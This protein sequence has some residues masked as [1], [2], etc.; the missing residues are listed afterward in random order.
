MI[1]FDRFLCCIS[2]KTFGKFIGWIGTMASFMMIY[3]L[4]LVL[5]AK[6]V[7][8]LSLNE[9]YFSG[10]MTNEG[11]LIVDA[12]TQNDNKNRQKPFQQ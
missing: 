8:L 4:F 7:N 3:A 1:V 12:F 6:S 9:R 11:E 5:T 10:K 2:L